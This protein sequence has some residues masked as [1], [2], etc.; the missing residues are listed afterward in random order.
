MNVSY[1][2]WYPKEP[3]NGG[4]KTKEGCVE[5]M[6]MVY[7]APNEGVAVGRWN[8]APCTADSKRYYVCELKPQT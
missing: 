6:N 7:W 3:N 5:L 4:S 2:N 8:D 1:T